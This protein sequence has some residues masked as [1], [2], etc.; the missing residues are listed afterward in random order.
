MSIRESIKTLWECLTVQE[1]IALAG[2]AILMAILVGSVGFKLVSERAHR[3]PPT[4][5]V[6]ALETVIPQFKVVTN[7]AGDAQVAFLAH[8]AT[9]WD[10]VDCPW[11]KHMIVTN[12]DRTL[13][14][15][16]MNRGDSDWSDIGPTFTNSADAISF[17]DTLKT[18]TAQS[19]IG[20]AKTQLEVKYRVMKGIADDLKGVPP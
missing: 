20:A 12:A 7:A 11:P 14:V 13:R 1:Q 3:A 8:G 6:P 17:R 18:M 9:N 19:V 15:C 2:L 10:V 4:S 5:D 16:I